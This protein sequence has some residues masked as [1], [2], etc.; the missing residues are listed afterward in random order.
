MPFE[1]QALTS[2]HTMSQELATC[3]EEMFD[4]LHNRIAQLL[5]DGLDKDFIPI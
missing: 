1:N 3:M 2:S 5:P 4:I